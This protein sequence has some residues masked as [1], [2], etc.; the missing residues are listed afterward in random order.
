MNLKN[1]VNLVLARNFKLQPRDIVFI[2]ASELVKW[3]RVISLLIPQTNL[4]KSYNPI[5]QNGLD[6]NSINIQ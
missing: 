1:P 5:V 3:N 2:P 6:A 4:F